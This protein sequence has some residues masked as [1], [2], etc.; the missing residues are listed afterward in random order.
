M[1]AVDAAGRVLY[2]GRVVVEPGEVVL[3]SGH[4]S[5]L[6]HPFL[7]IRALVLALVGGVAAGLASALTDGRV[8]S[9]WVVAGVLG[10]FGLIALRGELRRMRVRYAITDRRVR[11]E[12]GLIARR[13]RQTALD[14]VQEVTMHQ[15][16]TERFLGIGT[17]VFIT[18]ESHLD[19][20]LHGLAEPRRLLGSIDEAVPGR[21]RTPER[22]SRARMGAR[23]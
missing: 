12:T 4:P 15:T 11:I 16:V 2:A 22:R 1:A 18:D 23:I 9:G 21:I 5:R 13:K 6:A 20:R 8:Q 14:W 7:Y 19:F 17:V 10:V 3:F